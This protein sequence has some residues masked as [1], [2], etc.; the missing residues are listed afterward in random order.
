VYTADRRV[1]VLAA[2]LAPIATAAGQQIPA[3]ETTERIVRAE[4]VEGQVRMRD[5][6]NNRLLLDNRGLLVH[7]ENTPGSVAPEV[8]LQDQPT[9]FD[10]IYL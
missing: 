5:V 2:V 10:L 9:G 1:L 4:L 6:L 7:E 8:T 3:P